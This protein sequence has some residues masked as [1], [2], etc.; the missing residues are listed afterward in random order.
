L[1]D[2]LNSLLSISVVLSHVMSCVIFIHQWCNSWVPQ[3]LSWKTL[4]C[5]ISNDCWFWQKELN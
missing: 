5:G 1:L 3:N 4:L 2:T